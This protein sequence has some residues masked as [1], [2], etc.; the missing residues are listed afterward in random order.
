VPEPVRLLLVLDSARTT[1]ALHCVLDTGASAVHCRGWLRFTEEGEEA[2]LILPLKTLRDGRRW[3]TAISY[4][5]SVYV[6]LQFAFCGGFVTSFW[7]P[8]PRDLVARAARCSYSRSS[9]TTC[10]FSITGTV[11]FMVHTVY[12]C[13][14]PATID[15]GL[16]VRPVPV[17]PCRWDHLDTMPSLPC[18]Y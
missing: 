3:F 5:D 4:V 6:P 14:R 2:A 13:C 11:P 16:D 12:W 17:L 8:T 18:L 10:T 15:F 1:P 9:V 7:F